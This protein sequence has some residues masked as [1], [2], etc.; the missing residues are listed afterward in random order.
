MKSGKINDY[1]ITASSSYDAAQPSKARESKS[2]LA[3]EQNNCY[4]SRTVPYTEMILDVVLLNDF[5]FSLYVLIPLLYDQ[6]RE[7]TR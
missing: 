2:V 7:R 1:Q 3:H 6:L 4:I 5:S